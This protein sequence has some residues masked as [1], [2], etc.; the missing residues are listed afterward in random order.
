MA[1]SMGVG[2]VKSVNRASSRA[3][4][5]SFANVWWR[6]AILYQ[7]YPRSFMDSNADG[8]GDLNGITSKLEYVS[9]LGVEGIWISPFFTSPM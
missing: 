3:G 6:G 1:D 5:V 2:L 7:I 4:D 8:V 9:R